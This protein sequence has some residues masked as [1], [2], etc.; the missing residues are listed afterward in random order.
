GV[1]V[2]GVSGWLGHSC[3]SNTNFS[4]RDSHDEW[5]P[6][7]YTA[8]RDIRMG[9]ELTTP[10]GTN[11]DDTL[12]TRQR[13]LWQGFRIRCHCEVCSLKGQALKESDA[14]RRRMA[15]IHIQLENCVRMGLSGQNQ[16]ALKLTLELLSLVVRESHSDPW[17]IAATCW[18]GLPAA[19]L[20]GN[21]EM[22]RKM[23]YNH[24]AAL[25]RV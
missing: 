7:L 12:S 3:L 13:K 2:F 19:C 21:M 22:A 4:W 20:A 5:A 1:G 11:L 10:H 6:I 9:E 16:A 17:Y 15:A 25:V 18:D 24:V 14:R 8:A 23:A